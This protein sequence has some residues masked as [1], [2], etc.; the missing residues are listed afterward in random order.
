VRQRDVE[1]GSDRAG[2]ECAIIDW[3][4]IY[5]PEFALL[6]HPKSLRDLDGHTRLA[7]SAG[8]GNRDEAVHFQKSVDF[9]DLIVASEK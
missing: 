5:K 8:A 1:R 6:V 4:E 2:H 7:D 9:G 3:R